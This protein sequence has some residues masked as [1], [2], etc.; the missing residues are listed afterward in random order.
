MS[1]FESPDP[2]DHIVEEA[3]VIGS[4]HDWMACIS[5][6]TSTLVL[7]LQERCH[8][9]AA[10]HASAK[11]ARHNRATLHYLHTA[12]VYALA[13]YINASQKL[14]AAYIA[15]GDDDDQ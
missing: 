3:K 4:S 7:A 14:H 10:G 13:A 6:S 15:H 2:I 5:T 12:A 8:G 9:A 1:T 11:A